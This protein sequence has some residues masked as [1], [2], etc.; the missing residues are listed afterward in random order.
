[1]SA[2]A[3]KKSAELHK[4]FFL[5]PFFIAVLVLVILL[6]VFWYIHSL[7]R[8][9]LN[10]ILEYWN[11]DTFHKE[12]ST[13]DLGAF[14]LRKVAFGKDGDVRVRLRDFTSKKPIFLEAMSF[15]GKIHP[16]VVEALS[17][18]VE[19]LNGKKNSFLTDGDSFKAGSYMFVFRE[20][21]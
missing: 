15:G 10:G 5:N 16:A 6:L 3:E 12:I 18:P 7:S 9:K 13:V 14:H 11:T 2:D 4:P 17:A 19:F 1:M 8:L 20:K 21:K